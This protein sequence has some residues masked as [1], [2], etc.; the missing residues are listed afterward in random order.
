MTQHNSSKQEEYHSPGTLTTEVYER[1]LSRRRFALRQLVLSY[2]EFESGVIARWQVFIR[3]QLVP[4]QRALTLNDSTHR[5]STERQPEIDGLELLHFLELP[6]SLFRP[7]HCSS[8]LATRRLDEGLY[9]VEQ[10]L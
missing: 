5:T 4:Y 10:R 7:F 1:Q 6:R 9:Q 8:S 2:V 3:A